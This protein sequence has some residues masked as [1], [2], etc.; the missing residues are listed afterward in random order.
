[1][2]NQEQGQQRHQGQ[3]Q[4][5]GAGDRRDSNSLLLL[6][7]APASCLLLPQKVSVINRR[8][9]YRRATSE[10]RLH[11]AALKRRNHDK[12]PKIGISRFWHAHCQKVSRREEHEEAFDQLNLLVGF[13]FRGNSGGGANAGTQ[14]Q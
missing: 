9:P 2:I 7:A 5:A 10:A 14:E 3:A 1:M 8:T 12:S 11:N 13:N 6:L 4:E